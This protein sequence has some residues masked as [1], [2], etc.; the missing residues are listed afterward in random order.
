[1]ETRVYRIKSAD[2]ERL[3][4]VA[5]IIR[6]GGLVAIPT[7]TVY[8]IAANR[9]D[10]AAVAR[11][12]E[13]KGRPPDKRYTVHIASRNAVWSYLS[14]MPPLARYLTR[15][16]WPGP[17]TLVLDT[18]DGS[19]IGLRMP[20]HE[21]ARRII[22]L[23]RVPV[24]APSAN[25]S[26]KK[27]ARNLKEVLA[28][29]DGR[30]DAVVDSGPARLG[31]ASTVLRVKCWRRWRIMRKGSLNEE[32]LTDRQILIILLVCTGNMCRSPMAEAFFKMAIA[33]SLSIEVRDLEE[34][35][36]FV[37]SAG[38]D[39]SPGAPASSNAQRIL[40]EHGFDLSAHRSRHLEPFM[41]E[42][43]DI[44]YAMTNYHIETIRHRV[45]KKHL[46]KVKLLHPDTIQD[47]IGQPL[48]VYREVAEKIK[49]G[50]N[51]RLEEVLSKVPAEESKR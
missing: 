48:E 18:P 33:E 39:A 22:D 45:P 11:L 1:M 27:P 10:A 9:D 36:I 17:L 42:D 43:A 40:M 5:K 24:I 6:D 25:P 19:T 46:S 37:L 47:P 13:V 12:D 14:D 51:M 28:Y 21:I 20:D 31:I 16:H 32:A 15:K 34:N 49:E 35:G 3:V 26:G 41:V 23:A 4:E 30:I 50:V 7:E 29:F 44:V 8:G 38:S 2:D